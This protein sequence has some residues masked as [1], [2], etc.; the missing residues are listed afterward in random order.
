MRIVLRQLIPEDE[1]E[2]PYVGVSGRDGTL[3][4]NLPDGEA[5]EES[6]ALEFAPWQEWLGMTIDPET[7]ARYNEEDILAHCLGEMTFL[8]YEQGIVGAK[9]R[10][11]EQAVEEWEC[12]RPGRRCL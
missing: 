3:A 11:L 12:S 2:G 7:L 8:G 4:A 1:D 6:Y 5:R 9:A 10:R